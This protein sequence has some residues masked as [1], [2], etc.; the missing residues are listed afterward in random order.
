[1]L[2]RLTTLFCVGVLSQIMFASVATAG[3]RLE[4][5]ASGLEIPWGLAFL[6]DG[7]YLVTEHPGRLRIVAADG[8]VSGPVGGVPPVY[9]K[10]QGGL[11]DVIVDRDFVNNGQ[12]FLTYAE[13]MPRDNGTAIARATLVENAD[14]A[15]LENLSVIF[16]VERRKNTPVHYGGR[17]VILGDGNLLLTTG[18]GFSF[19]HESQDVKSQLGKTLRLTP[20]GKPA[21]GNPFPDAPYVWTWG[22]RNP[23]GLAI[24]ADGTVWLNEHGPQGGDEL[25]RIEPGKNFGWPA[26]CYCLDYTGAYVT[27]YTEWPGMEQPE[28]YWRPSIG[29]SGL[30]IYEGDQFPEWRGDFFVGALVNREVRRLHRGE[31]GKLIE[32]KLF[33]E[34]G[35][36][37][38]DVRTGP[39]GALYFTVE[40]KDGRIMRAV[41]DQP[42]PTVPV[43]TPVDSLVPETAGPETTRPEPAPAM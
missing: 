36:R 13:G 40:G 32:E 8:T 18:D 20:D 3:Y 33:S 25:N 37:V 22:H 10:S 34:I 1:M 17:L 41:S 23:Q 28:F 6:P 7:R 9:F 5:V 4:T 24:A 2:T 29:P 15:K 19:R 11:F 27:P 39:D 31:D 26:I 43:E 35:E 12:L 16:R 38:R 21:P 42:Q 30:A 14:G